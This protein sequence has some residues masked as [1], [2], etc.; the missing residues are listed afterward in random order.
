MKI[1][2]IGLLALVVVSCNSAK[3]L[4][5]SASNKVDSIAIFNTKWV[6]TSFEG[7]DWS[8]TNM[9][10]QNVYFTLNPVD[11][12]INGFSGC[13]SFM[14]NYAIQADNRISFSQLGSTKMACPDVTIDETKMISIFHRAATFTIDNGTLVFKNDAQEPLAKFKK[15]TINED[16]I[17]EKYW[18]LKTLDGKTI[19]MVKNQEKEIYFRLKSDDKSIVGFAGCNTLGGS[20]NLEQGNRIHFSNMLTT[21]KACPDVSVE[22]SAFLKIF[23]V[24]DHYTISGDVL[25]LKD[26]RAK[27]VAVFE[28]V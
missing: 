9:K 4:N 17:S 3:D 15:E 23:E 14:G 26:V 10:N 7:R 11:N 18:K 2:K 24:V 12:R 27:I 13:N 16:L 28:A 8:T 19:S 22:E 25:T 5:S 21:M 20:Y 1:I 6:I